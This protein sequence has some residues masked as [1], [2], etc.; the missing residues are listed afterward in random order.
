MSECLHAL[1]YELLPRQTRG[2]MPRSSYLYIY[3]YLFVCII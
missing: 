1:P 2:D 3:I